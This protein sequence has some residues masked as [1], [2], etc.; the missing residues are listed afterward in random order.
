MPTEV[1]VAVLAASVCTVLMAVSVT[2]VVFYVARR[3]R[4]AERDLLM[5]SGELRELVREGRAVLARTNVVV[6][7]V[8]EQMDDVAQITHTARTWVDRTDNLVN[9][10]G[11]V[12][13]SPIFLFSK[14]SRN[15]RAFASGVFQSLTTNHR[16]L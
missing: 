8:S 6:A 12:A 7:R 10:V 11:K 16:K 9:T 5:L 14:Y 13:E 1:Y 4:G 3:L 15:I 2:A